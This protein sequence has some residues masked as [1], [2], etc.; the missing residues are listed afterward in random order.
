[1]RFHSFCMAVCLVAAACNTGFAQD[2][3]ASPPPEK[4]RAEPQTDT[5]GQQNNTDS[6][7]QSASSSLTEKL[8]PCDGVLKP[9][10]IGD[11]EMTRLPP[12]TGEMPVIKPRDLPEQQPNRQ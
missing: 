7:G 10:A 8:D 5:Q 1:M 11:Q 12:A 4:C 6:N 3:D 2:I 9:P